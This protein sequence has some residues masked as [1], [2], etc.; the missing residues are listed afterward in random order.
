MS[1]CDYCY[2]MCYRSWARIRG[3]PRRPVNNADSTLVGGAVFLDDDYTR[4]QFPG[5]FTIPEQSARN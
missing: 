5:R 4:L 2:V 1:M 3:V